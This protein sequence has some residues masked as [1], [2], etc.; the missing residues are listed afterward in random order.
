MFEQK[1][2]V[3]FWMRANNSAGGTL[4]TLKVARADGG[5]PEPVFVKVPT[6]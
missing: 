3:A 1:F 2:E 4:G 5:I 6:F